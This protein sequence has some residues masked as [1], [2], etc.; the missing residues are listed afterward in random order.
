MM[1]FW[2]ILQLNLNIFHTFSCVSIVYFEQVN[3]SWYIGFWQKILENPTLK[4]ET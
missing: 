1:L 4:G 2:R 3:V